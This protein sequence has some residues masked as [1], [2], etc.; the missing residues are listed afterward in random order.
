MRDPA[1]QKDAL[2]TF[3]PGILGR[4]ASVKGYAV[5]A[6]DGPAGEVAW[7]SYAPEESYLLVT[8]RQHPHATS[9][10]VPGSAVA[11]VDPDARTVRVALSRREIE[12]SPQ[13]HDPTLPIDLTKIDLLVG[14]WPTWLRERGV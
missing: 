1:E 2:W 12:E 3:P 10:V 6:V 4:D 5:D 8:L 13:H 7:A 14:M 11:A 9:H